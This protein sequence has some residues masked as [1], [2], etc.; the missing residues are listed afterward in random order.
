MNIGTK[1]TKVRPERVQLD[2]ESVR[3]LSGLKLKCYEA[4]GE[5][6]GKYSEKGSKKP[7]Y[8]SRRKMLVFSYGD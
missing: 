7:C 4:Q 8:E 6:N 3:G 5:W 2:Q 1:G